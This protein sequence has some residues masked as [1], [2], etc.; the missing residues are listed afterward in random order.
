VGHS[1]VEIHLLEGDPGENQ[2]AGPRELVLSEDV[3]DVSVGELADP[4]A[5]HLEQLF[6]LAEG[7]RARG[8]NL[9]ATRDKTLLD[10]R[11]A[12]G[13]AHH[14]RG[15]RIVVLVGQGVV[16]T[17]HHTV[18]AAHAQLRV[19]EHRPLGRLLEGAD[20][21]HRGTARLVAVHALELSI[22]RRL[23]SI[24]LP[25]PVDECQQGIGGSAAAREDRF[26]IDGLP[27]ERRQLVDLLARNLARSAADAQGGVVQQPVP[28]GVA[29]EVLDGAGIGGAGRQRAADRTGHEA[30]SG[31]SHGWT[32]LTAW[33]SVQPCFG[34]PILMWQPMHCRWYAVIRAG[35]SIVASAVS[36]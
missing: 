18:A 1:G 32:S 19:I 6:P 15:D 10:P 28:P 16:R 14:P 8:T 31:N 27:L 36:P 29:A 24:R 3:I 35:L 33:Q 21:T 9:G 7:D 30:P 17:R 23:A 12:H 2:P 22:H 25:V 4:F 5:S 11:V 26:V 13:A 20:R 34:M